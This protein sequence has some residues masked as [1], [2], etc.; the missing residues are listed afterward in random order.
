MGKESAISLH[1]LEIFNDDISNL[2]DH[3]YDID[4]DGVEFKLYANVKG[5]MMKKKEKKQSIFI[6]VL[7]G[8]IV[9]F[10]LIANCTV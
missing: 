6:Q 2:R 3:R 8:A 10:V 4:A 1:C 5:Y 7:V 9:T